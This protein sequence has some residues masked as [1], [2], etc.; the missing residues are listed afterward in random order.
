[1]PA[2]MAAGSVR[3][4][5]AIDRRRRRKPARVEPDHLPVH[6][7]RARIIGL[8]GEQLGAADI[9]TSLGLRHVGRGHV[10]GFQPRLGLAQLLRQH[11]EVGTLQFENAGV[12]QQVHVGGGGIDQHGL[13]DVAQGLARG[14]HLALGKLGAVRGLKAVQHV[15][16][17]RGADAARGVDAALRE[18]AGRLRRSAWSSRSRGSW[19][20]AT[21]FRHSP[22]PRPWAGNRRAPSA[23]LH[24]WRAP[25]RAAS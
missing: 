16:R 14:K 25:P 5:E 2:A 6:R 12:A 22:S 4:R 8:G 11:L 13:L 23:R 15:L 9:E 7:P 18:I 1:M 19:S 24:R 3:R 17:D 20:T 10:A 21:G